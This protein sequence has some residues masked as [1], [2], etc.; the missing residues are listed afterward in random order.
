MGLLVRGHA[1]F[2][3]GGMCGCWWGVCMVADGGHAWLLV[4]GMHGCWQG[5]M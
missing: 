4:G 1:W 5:V 2:L 3:A